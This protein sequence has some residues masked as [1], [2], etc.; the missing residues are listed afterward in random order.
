MDDKSVKTIN[1]D[2]TIDEAE[3]FAFSWEKN[4]EVEMLAYAKE[5]KI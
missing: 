4:D 1:T 2:L 3:I 5:K